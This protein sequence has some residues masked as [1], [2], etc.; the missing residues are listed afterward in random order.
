[1]AQNWIIC[2]DISYN[3]TAKHFLPTAYIADFSNGLIGYIE[4]KA[5]PETV[6]SYHLELSENVSK[7]LQICEDLKTET[8]QKKYNAK[9]KV[10]KPL[11]ELL[12]EQTTFKLFGQYVSYKLNVFLSEIKNNNLPIAINVYRK[13]P[14]YQQQKTFSSAHLAAKLQFK[15][16]ENQIVYQLSLRENDTFFA[17]SER[18]TSILLNEPAWV[19]VDDSIYNLEQINANKLSPFLNKKEVII[20]EKNSRLYFETFINDIVKKVEIEAE[21]FAMIQKTSITRWFIKPNYYFLRDVYYLEIYF[22][23]EDVSF[24]HSNKAKFHSRLLLEDDFK[25]IQTKRN[26]EE[27]SRLLRTVE[28]SGL[29]QNDAGFFSFSSKALHKYENIQQLIEHKYFLEQHG[30]AIDLSAVDGKNIATEFGT[31]STKYD[32]NQDWFDVKMQIICGTFSFP[33]VEIISHLKAKNPFYELPDGTY[34]LIPKEWF[35]KFKSLIEFGTVSRDS[36]HLKKSQLP[37]IEALSDN[38]SEAVPTRKNTT[39]SPSHNLKATLRNYQVEG[40]K[41][42]LNH[43]SN[44]LGA[45]LADDMGLGKTLQTLAVLTHVKENLQVENQNQIVDLFSEISKT[46]EPLK[47][48]IIAPSS[49]IF[50]WKNEG[51]KFAPFL[52]SISYVGTDR[53]KIKTKLGLYDLIFTSYAIALKDIELF[54]SLKF[55]YLILDESQYIKNKNSKIFSAIHQIPTEQKITLSG[56]PIENSLDDLWSQMQFI[57]PDLLGSFAFFTRYFKIPI[58]KNKDETIIAELKNLISPYILRRTKEQVAKDLPPVSEQIFLS[59][60]NSKQKAFYE[61]EKSKA[62]NELLHLSD[63]EPVNKLNVLNALMRLRQIS[64]HPK[65]VDPTFTDDSGKFDDVVA[66]LET[67]IKAKQKVLL[68]SSFVQHIEMYTHWCRSNKVGFCTLTGE[69]ATAAREQEVSVF[70]NNPD[71]LL[72]FISLKAGGVG[73]NLTAASY[74]LLLDPWWNPFAENQAIARAHRIGQKQNITVVR[75][76]AK[77]SVEEKILLLQK[78]KKELAETIIDVNYLPSDID[79]DLAYILD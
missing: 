30:F 60:M 5:T 16:Q 50:N 58:E 68:F 51:K 44:H 3:E 29:E 18:R 38:T 20:L 77:D 78:K 6:Q 37:I 76:I 79:Q 57:N 74:V 39:Y 54:K 4:K 45:C 12:K 24:S 72:F 71:K 2:Y 53:K 48:L 23:Y 15:K 1:M 73:L 26:F 52:K 46:D 32:E 66:Y 33:F 21:G 75:F 64:N 40:V 19:L 14:L 55:R 27:E 9:N 8:L 62:R 34:F 11:A 13:N 56:T 69:T 47:A 70:Q 35:T 61:Q 41:W 63:N 49:L 7:L 22:Q 28:A 36:I 43:Y 25:V 31:V 17:P 67:L 59:E 10:K 42:L 65:L